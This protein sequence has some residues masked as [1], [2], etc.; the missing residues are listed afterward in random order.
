MSVSRAKTIQIFLPDGNPRSVR[1]AEI[2]SR[3]VRAVE[4]PRSKLA[5]A[6]TR[7]EVAQVGIYFLF[8]EEAESAQ[9]RVY[10]GES[11]DC[12]ARLKQH[13]VKKDFWTRAVAVTSKA[14]RFDKAQVRWLEWHAEAQATAAGRYAVEN[15]VSPN[16]PYI[17]EPVKADLLDTFDAI[18]TLLATLGFPVFEPIRPKAAPASRVVYTCK[19]RG[20]EAKAE[21]M[22][23][24]ML[25]LAGSEAAKAVTPSARGRYPDTI[26]PRLL[27]AGVIEAQGD[28]FVFV[29][30]HLF[31]SP[32]GAAMAVLGRTDNGWKKW[33]DP[34][35]RTLEEKERVAETL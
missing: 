30:D 4:I 31:K 22:E 32:S 13:H 34:R 5:V 23:D 27:Q 6:A 14:R 25:V 2:T 24:G 29:Q 35:G 28:R 8:D 11:E 33:K 3:T 21:F 10:V 7:K 26:R 16:E 1:I 15:A 19:G 18:S 20:V 9:A 12:L 17:T